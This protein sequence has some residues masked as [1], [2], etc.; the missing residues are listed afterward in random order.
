VLCNPGL[1]LQN[2]QA[3]ASIYIGMQLILPG[4]T[5][6]NHRHTPSAVRFVIEGQG[7]FT[8][9]SGERL[10]MEKGDLILT[11]ARLVA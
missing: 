3:T 9:V 1:G 10:P 2:M 4:E 7:G 6:P 5:A 8:V 11:A